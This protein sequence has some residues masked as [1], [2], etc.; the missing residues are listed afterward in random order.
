MFF[1]F[2]LCKRTA[3]CTNTIDKPVLDQETFQQLLAAAYTL[4]EQNC[5]PVKETPEHITKLLQQEIIPASAPWITQQRCQP[6]E[7]RSCSS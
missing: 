6:L 1:L 3:R 2:W 7:A 5:L 4:Q